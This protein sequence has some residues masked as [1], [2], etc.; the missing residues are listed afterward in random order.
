MRSA[1]GLGLRHLRAALAAAVTSGALLAPAGAAEPIN[2][3]TYNLRLNEPSD[4]PNAWP[5]RKEMVKA[6]IRHHEFDIVA[7]QEGLID[8]IRELDA[9]PGW[10]RVGVGRDDGKEGGEHSAI[11][12]RSVRFELRRHG[13]FWLSATPDKPS[14]SWDSRC[15]N[16]LATWAELRDKQ[17][18]RE[19][20]VF[21]VHFD[22]EGVVSRRE[23]ALLMLRQVRELAGSKPVVC[24]GDYNAT[25]ESEPIR[26]MLG[27]LRDAY[28]LSETPPYGPVGSFNDF[29]FDTPADRRIDYVFLTPGIRVLK[30]AVLTDSQRGRYTSDHFPVLVRLL[31]P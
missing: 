8:Q 26:T 16:R 21:S 24:M 1:R 27:G 18:G 31:M 14:I 12:F 20:L 22:H 30:Y 15:C 28:A 25:P 3:A 6:L 5:H 29:K 7:T 2:V 19:F 10:A 13:D 9:M 11:Y 17:S 4:G 23:S